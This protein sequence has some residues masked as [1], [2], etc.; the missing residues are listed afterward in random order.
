MFLLI[1]DY[2]DYNVIFPADIQS[3]LDT[4]PLWRLNYR[5]AQW[6]CRPLFNLKETQV[7]KYTIMHFILLHCRKDLS[8]PR[9]FLLGP[10]VKHNIRSRT[11]AN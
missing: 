3:V 6:L 11:V 10:A 2:D 5:H 4:V 1:L 9:Q 8:K 7:L